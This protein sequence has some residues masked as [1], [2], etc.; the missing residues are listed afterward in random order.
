MKRLLILGTTIGLLIIANSALPSIAVSQ[1]YQK[2]TEASMTPAPRSDYNNPNY[3]Y[4]GQE[5]VPYSYGYSFNMPN[6]A[7]WRWIAE[8][9]FSSGNGN[10]CIS[11]HWIRRVPGRCEETTSHNIRRGNYI[12]IVPAGTVSTCRN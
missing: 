7:K 12:Q 8:R 5:A 4:N 9:C 10:T 3:A 2:V 1:N 11:G 6:D